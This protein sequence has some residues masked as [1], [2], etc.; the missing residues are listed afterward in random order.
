MAREPITGIRYGAA[1]SVVLCASQ[2]IFLSSV[3]PG[4]AASSTHKAAAVP[5]RKRSAKTQKNN[6]KHHKNAATEPQHELIP[7]ILPGHENRPRGP[8]KDAIPPGLGAA[9]KAYETFARLAERYQRIT[10]KSFLDWRRGTNNSYCW[11]V[12][13]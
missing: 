11:A 8:K 9:H 5:S 1:F 7:F 2:L 4:Q 13:P 6:G 12:E 10:G 3:K